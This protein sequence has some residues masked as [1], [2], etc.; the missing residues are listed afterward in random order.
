MLNTLKNFSNITLYLSCENIGNYLEFNRYGINSAEYQKK[1]DLIKD[2]G[3]KFIFHSVLSNLSVI[4]FYDFLGI[5]ID[6][7]EFNNDIID[8][9]SNN[10]NFSL[11][12]GINF[13]N[14]N[15]NDKIKIIKKNNETIDSSIIEIDNEKKRLVIKANDNLNKLED[16]INTSIYNYK[17]QF[18]IIF[19]YSPK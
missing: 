19:K 10:N 6:F 1:L 12:I 7:N 13:I 15:L 3:I 11:N 9:L 18:S 17:N 14:F 16:L 8:I 2:S 4:G 5:P